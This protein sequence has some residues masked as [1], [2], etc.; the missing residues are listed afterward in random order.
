MKQTVIKT[1]F[2]ILLQPLFFLFFMEFVS[3][4]VTINEFVPDPVSGQNEWVELYNL[5][6]EPVSLLGWKISDQ[7]AT[8]HEYALDSLDSIPADG[9]VVFE[10]PS[11][12]GWLN[13]GGDTV[14]L[15]DNEGNSVDSYTYS[16]NPGEGKSLGRCPNGTG[17]FV[18][19]DTPTKGEANPNPTEVPT[20]TL[21]PVPTEVPT[22]TPEPAET[23]T[24]VPTSTPVP[25]VKPTTKP[26]PTATPTP[27]DL[28]AVTSSF[29][30]PQGEVL[31]SESTPTGP[32]ELEDIKALYSPPEKKKSILLPIF[33][34]GGGGI[35]IFF[36]VLSFLKKEEGEEKI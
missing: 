24:P 19:F 20:P 30:G 17:G 35:S 12:D 1:V 10:Y 8:P 18:V 5:G 27:A 34:I 28:E 29:D 7:L 22:D 23:P 32:D 25:T 33:L 14:I 11:G 36:S 31:G 2:L 13:N 6:T 21:T 9:F 3:A 26:S 15:K 16:S 4:Q